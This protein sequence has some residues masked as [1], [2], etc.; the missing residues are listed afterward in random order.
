MDG[1]G[2]LFGAQLERAVERGWG[3]ASVALLAL[4]LLAGVIAWIRVNRLAGPAKA[5]PA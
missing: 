5:G 3:I 1:A 2:F 4:F